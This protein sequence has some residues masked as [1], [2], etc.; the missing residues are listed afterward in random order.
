MGFDHVTFNRRN[1]LAIGGIWFLAILLAICPPASGQEPEQRAEDLAPRE[2]EYVA[3]RDSLRAMRDALGHRYH[4]ATDDAARSVVL[5][6]AS[7]ALFGAFDQRLFPAWLGTPWTFHGTATR[8]GDDPIAC[9]YFV[10]TLLQHAG[11]LLPRVELAQLPSE[12]MIRRLIDASLIT[13][14]SEVPIDRFLQQV[15]QRGRGIY[16]VGLDIHTGF[17]LCDGQ[18]VEFVHS[19]YVDPLCVVREEARRAS[20][21]LS[22]DYRVLGKLT[23]DHGLLKCWI[24]GEPVDRRQPNDAGASRAVPSNGRS[25]A[26]IARVRPRLE[27]TL[28]ERG[29]RYGA[30]LFVRIFKEPRELE[31]WLDDGERFRHFRTYPIRALNATPGPKVRQGDGKSPEGFYYVTPDRMNPWSRF[32]LSFNVGYPNAYD[33]HHG[34]TGSALMVHGDTVSIG[35]FAMTDPVIEEIFALADAA[36]RNGQRF[37]RVHIFPFRMT[38]DAMARH[39]GD[40][41]HSFWEN[42]RTGYDVFETTGRP[43]NV[44]VRRGRYAFEPAID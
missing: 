26:A 25:R 44:R 12:T 18:R 17:V 8:P 3:L 30:P 11:L 39:S 19:S 7:E 34:R 29:L 15:R 27:G 23:G 33:R 32:H 1:C 9:G 37:F 43:P 40:R 20:I 6:Q 24:L 10:T 21:L 35:C 14:F 2:R 38:A 5:A 4:Q 28:R 22:S 42:L 36:F 16:L 31:V 13:R 41:W